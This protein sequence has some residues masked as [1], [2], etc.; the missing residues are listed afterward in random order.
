M[1]EGR[2]IHL[3]YSYLYPP[4]CFENILLSAN[5]LQIKEVAEANLGEGA[6]HHSLSSAVI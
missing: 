2:Q 1:L 3:Q 6:K 5:G 4:A